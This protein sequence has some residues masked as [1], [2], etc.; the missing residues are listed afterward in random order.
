MLALLN[1]V[2]RDKVAIDPISRPDRILGWFDV[3]VGRAQFD[4]PRD[5]SVE[6]S[7]DRSLA[8]DVAEPLGVTL[9]HAG[10]VA[11]RGFNRSLVSVLANKQCEVLG[12]F[13]S[14]RDN[15][16]S[17]SPKAIAQRT[18][19]VVFERSPG[20][21]GDCL[22]GHCQGKNVAATKELVRNFLAGRQVSRKFRRSDNGK[23]EMPRES[24]HKLSLLDE[25]E[26]E[27]DGI[28]RLPRVTHGQLGPLHA[29]G[30]KNSLGQEE[31][32][33]KTRPFGR[34]GEARK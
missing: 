34:R 9:E 10:F 21:D 23:A 32:E 16:E 13:G 15:D 11:L 4:G 30:I 7:D 25:A 31:A 2:T 27:K 19:I 14:L 33:E 24:L 5:D 17:R 20:G 29:G 1:R 22:A 3:N 6:Q 8:R 26:F 18:N 12:D 28:D